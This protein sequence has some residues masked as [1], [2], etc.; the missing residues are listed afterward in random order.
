M[1][2]TDLPLST[3]KLSRTRTYDTSLL[4]TKSRPMLASPGRTN[5]IATSCMLNDSSES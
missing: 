1:V 3:N 5:L 4:K 2:H